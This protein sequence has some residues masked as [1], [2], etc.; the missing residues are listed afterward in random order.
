MTWDTWCATLGE[1]GESS[2]GVSKTLHVEAHSEVG[3]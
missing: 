3:Q 1:G 2:G